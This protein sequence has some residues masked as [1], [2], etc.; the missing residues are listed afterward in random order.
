MSNKESKFIQ[1]F[2]GIAAALI[3]ASV[4]GLVGMYRA[5]GIVSEKVQANE[6][7]INEVQAYHEKDVELIRSSIKEIKSDQKVIMSDIKQ[8]LKEIR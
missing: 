2:A 6:K 5:S 4:I 8:I 1:W 3:I 7:K